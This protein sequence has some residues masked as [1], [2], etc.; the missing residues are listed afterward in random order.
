MSSARKRVRGAIARRWLRVRLPI[1]RGSKSREEA[2]VEREPIAAVL[3][4]ARAGDLL[5]ICVFGEGG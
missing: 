5:E 1:L 3:V 2:V 4:L